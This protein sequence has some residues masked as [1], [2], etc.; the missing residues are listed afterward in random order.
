MQLV[1]TFSIPTRNNRISSI[2]L[3]ND[4]NLAAVIE[5]NGDAKSPLSHWSQAVL[6]DHAGGAAQQGR[7]GAPYRRDPSLHRTAPDWRGRAGPASATTARSS[8]RQPAT[9]DSS[10]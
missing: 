7:R 1:P 3:M 8:A 9:G 2:Y 10:R 4:T 6:A 5:G